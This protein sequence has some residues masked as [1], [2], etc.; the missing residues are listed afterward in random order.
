M[1]LGRFLAYCA[2]PA[3]AW[4]RLSKSDRT[5]LVA[6]YAGASYVLTLVALLAV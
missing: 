6:A 4:R 5:L 2:H 3:L 1:T